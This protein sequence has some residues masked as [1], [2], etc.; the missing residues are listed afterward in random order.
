VRIVA[1]RC[2]GHG[3]EELR[4]AV[5]IYDD[6]AALLSRYDESVIGRGVRASHG[7]SALGHGREKREAGPEPGQRR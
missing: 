3:D 7:R 4:G 2:G 6:P 5:E 1:V